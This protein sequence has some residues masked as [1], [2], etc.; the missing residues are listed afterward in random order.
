MKSAKFMHFTT[1]IES[2]STLATANH[3]PQSR[4]FDNTVKTHELKHKF[5]SEAKLQR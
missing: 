5:T 1:S 2:H 4:S 3:N